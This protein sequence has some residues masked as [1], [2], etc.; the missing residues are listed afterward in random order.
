MQ[1]PLLATGGTGTYTWNFGNGT[2]P[3]GVVLRSDPPFPSWFPGGAVAGLIGVA[4][5]TGTYNFTLSVTSGSTTISQAFNV[6]ITALNQKDT[7]IPDAFVGVAYSYTLS[8]LN[9]AGA[10]T[11]TPTSALPPGLSLSTAGV[12]AGTPTAAGFYNISYSISDGTDTVFKGFGLLVGPV[13]FI[14]PALLPN[15]TRGV[16]Y[17]YTLTA[18]GGTAPYTFTAGG[19]PSGL[20]LNSSTGVISGTNNN[21]LGRWNVPITVTDHNN[22]SYTKNFSLNI[23]VPPVTAGYIQPYGNLDDCTIGMSCS[24]GFTIW[25]GGTAPFSWSASGLPAGMSL[26]FGEGVTSG[27]LWGG[28]AELWGTASATGT[29]N[30]TITVTDAN[31]LVTTQTFPLKISPLEQFW[32]GT[33]PNGTRGS[34]YSKVLR[35]LGGTGTGYTATVLGGQM[36]TGVTI[37]GLTASGTPVENGFFNGQLRFTDSASNSLSITN[38][39]NIAPTSNVNINDGADL[40]QLVLNGFYS[41]Q[42]SACCTAVTWTTVGGTLPPGLT[43]SGSGLLSGTP[44]ASG[45][46]TFTAK[47]TDNGNAANFGLRVFT[48]VVTPLNI[49]N[50]FTLQYGN[51]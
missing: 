28:D 9:N 15:V 5:T 18:A 46:Y 50:N 25:N 42:L 16:A 1:I 51:Q 19:L 30:I 17:S 22:L 26:R 36:P 27:Y 38:Y 24:R 31:G 23:L 49:A 10:L 21:N 40:G 39:F 43:L 41:R 20:S 45:A 44:T 29:Y 37:S 47:A 13:R 12:F 6:K 2:L 32:E 3:P 14:S 35:V 7:G 4:T 48:I 33:L 11:F 8:A 34:A